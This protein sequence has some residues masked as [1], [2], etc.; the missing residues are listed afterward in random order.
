MM[1]NHY[2]ED[3]TKNKAIPCF[4]GHGKV[5][6]KIGQVYNCKKAGHGKDCHAGHTEKV[7]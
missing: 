2:T 6:R 7:L 3:C 5:P 1:E 4:I